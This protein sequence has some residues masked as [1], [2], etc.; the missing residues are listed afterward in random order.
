MEIKRAQ[1]SY[2]EAILRNSTCVLKLSQKDLSS[3][4]LLVSSSSLVLFET[5]T[6]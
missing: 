6:K 1:C 2:Y 3:V 5:S 4:A